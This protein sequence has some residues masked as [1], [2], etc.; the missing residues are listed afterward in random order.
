MTLAHIKA[1][2]FE[3]AE[4]LRDEEDMALYLASVLEDGDTEEFL[5]ALSDV[6]RARGM[7]QLAQQTGLSRESLYKTL[8]PGAK[9]RFDTIRRITAALGIPLTVNAGLERPS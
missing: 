1:K 4:H 9:P 3:V 7:A 5:S 6:A 8:A 2:P